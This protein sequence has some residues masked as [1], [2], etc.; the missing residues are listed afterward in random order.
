MKKSL[1]ATT[2]VSLLS[3]APNLYAKSSEDV[4]TIIVTANRFEQVVQSTALPVEVITREEIKAIQAKSLTEVLRRLPGVQTSGNGG[5]GQTQSIFIRGVDS[6]RILFLIDGVRIGSA[7]LGS[8]TISAIPLVGVERIE[9]LRGTRAAL[10]GSDAI[11]GVINIITNNSR[12]EALVSAGIGSHNYKEGEAAVSGE[13]TPN[14]NG[15]ISAS[16]VS[17]EGFSASSNDNNE[18]DDGYES[19]DIIASLSYVINDSFSVDL[20]TLYHEGE[21]EYDNPA[22]AKKD[23]RIANVAASLNYETEKLDSKLTLASNQDF[24]KNYAFNSEYQTDRKEASLVNMYKVNDTLSI[25]GGIDWYQDDVSESSVKYD[26]TS[27]DNTA[28]YIT[29]Y[30]TKKTYQLEA[31][32]RNDDNERYGQNSTWQVGG[33][34]YLID[35][36]RLTANIGTG[37]KAPSYNDLYYPGFGNPKLKAEKSKNYEVALEASNDLFDWRVA[38]YKTELDEMIA[39]AGTGSENIGEVEITGIEIVASFDT[40]PLSHDISIDIMDPENKETNKQLRR[41][42]KESAKWNIT[43]FSDDWQSDLSYLYQ[44]KRYDDA[45]NTEEL[46]AYSI[47]DLSA[48]YF[49]TDAFTLRAKIANLLDE[50]YTLSKDYNTQERSY[51]AS[52]EYQF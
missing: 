48:S 28:L 34:V 49:I 4:E 25:G 43:Y 52:V 5:Y 27:R 19:K 44:G 2:V 1:I 15:S 41:R 20:Q 31:A 35:D 51:Y 38:A 13:I 46:D 10:Y 17:T 11:G 21:V 18:D 8:A 32:I 37:F 47:V 16:R 6:K 24:S 23:E 14:L 42:A 26:E 9:Y 7:T 33:G 22:D 3:A 40:G 12:S 39:F 30:Y 50:E 45:Q 36:Y 29:S